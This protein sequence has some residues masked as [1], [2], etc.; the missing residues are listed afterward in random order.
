[1]AL[2]HFGVIYV[3]FSELYSKMLK[4]T[5]YDIL[6]VNLYYITLYFGVTC[7]NVLQMTPE[8]VRLI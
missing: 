8:Y 3:L 6:Q 1:M 2:A 7:M 5:K 4:S